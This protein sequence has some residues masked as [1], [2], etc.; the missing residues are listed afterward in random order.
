MLGA[1][2]GILIADIFI[3]EGPVMGSYEADLIAMTLF[4]GMLYIN[5]K[6]DKGHDELMLEIQNSKMFQE[7]YA[8]ARRFDEDMQTS[9]MIASIRSAVKEEFNDQSVDRPGE[10]EGLGEGS[11]LDT[12]E[13]TSDSGR[14]PEVDSTG[15]HGLERLQ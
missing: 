10:H 13:T 11:G 14:K 4:L 12:R 8:T 9:D 3:R 7:G 2:Y 5:R 6:L 15:V 1:T